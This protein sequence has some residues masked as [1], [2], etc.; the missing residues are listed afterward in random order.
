[1]GYEGPVSNTCV[2]DRVKI[3]ENMGCE[4]ECVCAVQGS[5]GVLESNLKVSKQEHSSCNS[6]VIEGKLSHLVFN[7][8]NPAMDTCV[9][10]SAGN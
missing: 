7:V 4:C 3:T 1:M 2:G 6:D 5:G 9:I 8:K 10:N